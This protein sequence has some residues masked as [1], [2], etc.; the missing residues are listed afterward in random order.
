M[1]ALSGEWQPFF[2]YGNGVPVATAV[3]CYTACN[4]YEYNSTKT[5]GIYSWY[6]AWDKATYSWHMLEY[7]NTRVKHMV[8]ING[9]AFG[10]QEEEDTGGYVP[11]FGLKNSGCP[12][13]IKC[14]ITNVRALGKKEESGDV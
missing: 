14:A 13:L 6:T 2:F 8:W 12:Q 10:Q 7:Y 1:H 9:R 5:E 3:R 4:G 11:D